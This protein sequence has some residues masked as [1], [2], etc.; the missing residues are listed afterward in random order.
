M[1]SPKTVKHPIERA[2][3]AEKGK[4]EMGSLYRPKY[5]DKKTG[6]SHESAIWWAKF[7]VHG[8][9]RRESTDTADYAEAKDFLKKREGE[10]AKRFLKLRLDQAKTLARKRQAF[11]T[12]G[13]KT[14]FA[15]SRDGK[16]LKIGSSLEPEKRVLRLQ[17]G[18]AERL[19]ILAMLTTNQERKLH[20]QFAHLRRH[21]EWFRLAPELITW[22]ASYTDIHKAWLAWL[23]T[24]RTD[25]KAASV[26]EKGE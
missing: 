6:E 14:Y 21:G 3:Q 8:Q 13:R 18:N 26:A 20:K 22:L 12:S 23:T 25:E 16:F 1:A 19:E 2:G 15:I 5:K 17:N 24:L 10:A 4:N 9:M 7:Y 11:A